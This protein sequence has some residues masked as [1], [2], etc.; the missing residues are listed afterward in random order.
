LQITILKLFFEYI[1]SNKKI[2]EYLIKNNFIKDIILILLFV[3]KKSFFDVKELAFNYLIEVTNCLPKQSFDESCIERYTTYYYYP[4][5]EEKQEGLEYKDKFSINKF[6]YKLTELNEKQKKL[7]SYYDKKLF[8]E[9][10]N[11]I[12]QKAENFF[13]GKKCANINLNILLLLAPK[14]NLKVMPQ[15]LNIIQ[16]E[17][18]NKNTENIALILKSNKLFQFLLDTCYQAYLIKNAILNKEEFIPGLSLD[19]SKQEDKEQIADLILS[20]SSNIILNIF[21]KDIYKLDYLLTW[22]KYY[23]QIKEDKKRLS[24][25][26]KFIF[27]YF[28]EKIINRFTDNDSKNKNSLTE[29]LFLINIV[30][31]FL[32]LHR[33]QSLTTEGDLKEMENL[34]LEVCPQ[35]ICQFIYIIQNNSVESF[36]ED[37]L[38]LLKDKWEEYKFIKKLFGNLDKNN[39][40]YDDEPNVYDKLIRSKKNIFI[41]ELKMY[42]T[43][44]EIK[45]NICNLGTK[46]IIIK[47]HY[48]TLLLTAVVHHT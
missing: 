33:F 16:T 4:K 5:N 37:N 48:Y 43:D 3:Y 31:E 46:L 21:Y 11:N 10:M 6:D 12:Y 40:S 13:M 7:L 1:L 18:Q 28:L 9:S 14:S 17:L 24:L 42:F 39:I 36:N 34:Y 47:Y 27:H 20:L 19:V 2:L 8:N 30:F 22:S 38:Y 35:F 26:I 23:N 45:D 44:L 15:I 25:N 41:N 29:I 32:L